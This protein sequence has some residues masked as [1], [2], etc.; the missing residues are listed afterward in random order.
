MPNDHSPLEAATADCVVTGAAG[1]IGSHLVD[2]LLDLGH[3]VVGVDCFTDY[4]PR[5]VKEENLSGARSHDSFEMVEADLRTAD[6]A[7]IVAGADVVFHLAAMG[8]LLR[9]WTWFD[10]YL[11]CNV[12]ATQRL[13]E[14]LVNSEVRHLVHISTSSV[15]GRDS[16]GDE[17]RAKKPNSP[18][19]VTKLAAEQLVLAYARNFGVP[20]TVL[21]YFS[22]YGPRQRPD[23]GYHI[24]IERLLEGDEITVFGDGSQVRANTYIDDCIEAT[25]AAM[26]VRPRGRVYNVGG[27]EPITVLD[28]IG[29]LEQL[30]ETEAKLIFG[31]PRPGEQQQAIA[32]VERAADELGWRPTT[33]IEAG[34]RRQVAWHRARR[35]RTDG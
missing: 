26:G 29:L 23:M 19:G 35:R 3:R 16:S 22:I 33:G 32:V 1:F 5:S 14:A 12:T 10:E 13:L 4:Y 11:S 17:E 21:R 27:G 31:P 20:A 9:S 6:L 2:R 34:L 28:A 18:Y 15:Y 7:A 25:V 8:G 30:T 24:F